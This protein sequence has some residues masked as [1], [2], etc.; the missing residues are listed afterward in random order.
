MSAVIT[1]GLV[2]VIAMALG[3]YSRKGVKSTEDFLVGGRSFGSLLLFILVVGEV[4][5]IGTVI[6]FP[7]GV[8]AEGAG[9]AIWFMGYILLGYPIGYFLL[10]LLFKAGRRYNAVTLPDV[11]R[12]HFNSRPLELTAALL[13][14]IFLIPWAQLQLTGLTVALN[15]LGLGFTPLATVLIGVGIALVF[16]LMSGIKAPAYVS[17]VKDFALIF[18]IVIVAV[19]VLGQNPSVADIVAR[20]DA[21][22]D[23]TV[24][25]HGRPMLHTMSTLLFQ[26]LGF[27]MFPFIVQ[28]I[29]SSKSARTVRRTQ[30]GMPL[31]MLMYPFLLVVAYY[32]I[33]TVPGLTGAQTNLAFIE[34][35]RNL[36]PEWLVGVVAG[37]AALCAIVVLAAS[38]L[39]IGT[40][41]S[42]NVLVNVPERRQ[43]SY[44]RV[45]IAVYLLVSIVLT[46]VVPNL[47]GALINTSYYGFTQLIV[48]VLLL[49]FGSR[50]RPGVMAAGLAGGVA[51]ALGLYLTGADLGGLSLGVPALAGNLAIVAAGRLLWPRPQRSEAIWA[52]TKAPTGT[53]TAGNTDPIQDQ[54][55]ALV[56]EPI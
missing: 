33:S 37:G 41:V 31:Y 6:G 16:A 9:F 14:V 20:A 5:S 50:V 47:M 49:I 53:T 28:A 46:L 32:A 44:V 29:M 8:Y 17:F 35:T 3:L 23:H 2:L 48:P 56:K 7:G 10:P 1:F 26:A 39:C 11:F 51:I 54:D 15:G 22:S 12:G 25:E 4:Y 27:Y 36:L 18:A 34:V 45:I 19:F 13:C 40:L 24:I 38:A 42:R 43:K 55:S 52:R 30:I 21:V